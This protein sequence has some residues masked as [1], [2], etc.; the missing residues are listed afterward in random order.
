[1]KTPSQLFLFRIYYSVCN[2]IIF[3]RCHHCGISAKSTPMMRRGPDGPRTLCN[4][5]GLMWANKVYILLP[6]CSLVWFFFGISL[7]CACIILMCW[8][9]SRCVKWFHLVQISYRPNCFSC[10]VWGKDIYS[11]CLSF[12]RVQWETSQNLQQFFLCKL[13]DKRL[14]LNPRIL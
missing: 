9:I 4:A 3:F 14:Y 5:C 1:M 2:F 7:H 13:Y 10:P 12:C 6:C 11:Y 8:W